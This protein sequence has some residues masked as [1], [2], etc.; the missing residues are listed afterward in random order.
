MPRIKSK[1]YQD[2]RYI[3]ETK[4]LVKNERKYKNR[5]K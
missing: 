3:I 4:G 1:V 2:G 5:N